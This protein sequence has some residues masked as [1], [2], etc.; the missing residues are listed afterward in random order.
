MEVINRDSYELYLLFHQNKSEF[1]KCLA[2]KDELCLEALRSLI[3]N[4]KVTEDDEKCYL[5]VIINHLDD[6]DVITDKVMIKLVECL[7]LLIDKFPNDPCLQGNN[8][9]TV[10]R[11]LAKQTNNTLV[12]SEVSESL[13]KILFQE[14]SSSHTE[15]LDI[16][17]TLI[18]KQNDNSKLILESILKISISRFDGL[19]NQN[20]CYFFE[21]MCQTGTIKL[22]ANGVFL[23]KILFKFFDNDDLVKRKQGLYLIKTVIH[24]KCLESS[25]AINWMKFILIAEALEQSQSHLIQP[26][27]TNLP[28]IK[29]SQDHAHFMFILC[30]MIITHENTVIKN[31]GLR[32]VLNEM[33]FNNND[34][35]D[36]KIIIIMSQLNSTGLYADDNDSKTVLFEDLL[37]LFI[38]RNFDVVFRNVNTIIWTSVPFFH[39]ITA[40]HKSIAK[41]PPASFNENFIKILK[42]QASYVGKKIQNLTIRA[43]VQSIYSEILLILIQH[44]EFKEL[45]KCI[46]I[47]FNMADCP[48]AFMNIESCFSFM[49]DELLI[50]SNDQQSMKYNKFLF[51]TLLLSEKHSYKWFIEVISTLPNP[52]KLIIQVLD[53]VIYDNVHFIPAYQTRYLQHL[54]ELESEL[55]KKD[56]C[57]EKVINLFDIVN[58]KR[59]RFGSQTVDH[60]Q[61]LYEK[62][63]LH[64]SHCDY[65]TIEMNILTIMSKFLKTF[66]LEQFSEAIYCFLNVNLEDR[67]MPTNNQYLKCYIEICFNFCE[68]IAKHERLNETLHLNNMLYLIESCHHEDLLN[69]IESLDK[70]LSSTT[71]TTIPKQLVSDV[72]SRLFTEILNIKDT[73]MFY[74]CFTGFVDLVFN[75]ASCEKEYWLTEG[76][77]KYFNI[78]MNKCTGTIKTDM[79]LKFYQT[80]FTLQMDEELDPII[81]DILK[82][83]VLYGEILTK[84]QKIEAMISRKINDA[85]PSMSVLSTLD[86][87]KFIRLNST[88]YLVKNCKNYDDI[89]DELIVEFGELSKKKPKG[90]FLNSLV[91]HQKLRYLQPVLFCNVLSLKSEAI[92]MN[93]IININNQANISA[94]VEIILARFNAQVWKLL[95][96]EQ[97]DLKSTTLKSIFAILTMQLRSEQDPNAVDLQLQNVFKHVMPYTM[98]QNF[99]TRVFAQAAIMQCWEHLQAVCAVMPPGKNTQT[100]NDAC[101]TIQKSLKAKNAAKYFKIAQSDFR[102]TL[103][104]IDQLF[105]VDAFYVHILRITNMSDDGIISPE[106]C[107]GQN[108]W[109]ESFLCKDNSLELLQPMENCM[110]PE[111]LV[112]NEELEIVEQSAVSS[113]NLQQ[114][115]VPYKF[116]IPG[117]KL[118]STLPT[119]FGSGTLKPRSELTVVASL[120]SRPPNLGGLARTCEV[121]GAEN[122]IIDSL[123][124]IENTEFKA[125]S[126]TAE[127]W[128]KITEIKVWQLF[129]YLLNMKMQGYAIVGAEQTAKSKNLIGT[130]IPKKAVLLLG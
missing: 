38:Q 107:D 37:N 54:N 128:L 75:L 68:S 82:H 26:T 57:A 120:V 20:L 125:L 46:Q 123:K 65:K 27:L 87:S 53:A 66:K 47:I 78:I 51:I 15:V 2:G 45:H 119:I 113:M 90:Y 19:A 29:F 8:N 129:D 96:D 44:V 115:Y 49:K 11:V 71:T 58:S 62:V 50:L 101:A 117:G 98:G 79:L 25:V 72:I 17:N 95:V 28:Q 7:E 110:D 55:E 22:D 70:F 116:Q 92:L 35:N 59:I 67:P 86:G 97:M 23:H 56:L 3:V 63:L 94:I 73:K 42:N 126:K 16:L 93:E 31:W 32:Y 112:I 4:S 48:K 24:M 74:E 80:L 34:D 89:V 83:G 18:S 61:K 121:F 40:I 12:S 1:N 81:I 84:D 103:N 14:S 33:S 114:K 77:L 64:K 111:H 124:I 105:T 109:F 108:T 9:L 104:V 69:V 30:K 13:V 130:P 85:N 43:G 10:L 76:V 88:C 52:D 39:L 41:L 106:I 6:T 127:K 21:I 118:L 100:G 5:N 91:H 36:D 99:G 60:F 102:F 122:F